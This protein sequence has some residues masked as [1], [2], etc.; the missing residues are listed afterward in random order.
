M[1]ADKCPIRHRRAHN[2]EFSMLI[3]LVLK[4]PIWKHRI[5]KYIC[6]LIYDRWYIMKYTRHMVYL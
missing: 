1:G 6:V 5:R 4:S 2:K 3:V